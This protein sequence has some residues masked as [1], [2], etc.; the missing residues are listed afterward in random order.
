M[1]YISSCAVQKLQPLPEPLCAL[2]VPQVF[3]PVPMKKSL[4]STEV[5]QKNLVRMQ[6]CVS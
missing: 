6:G 1:R 2:Q 3:I 5:V 4:H